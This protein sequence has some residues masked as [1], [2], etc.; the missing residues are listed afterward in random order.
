MSV[1]NSIIPIVFWPNGQ[2]KLKSFTLSI[3][4]SS[5]LSLKR[6]KELLISSTNVLS[7]NVDK[8][9]LFKDNGIPLDEYDIENLQSNQIIFYSENN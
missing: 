1:S 9:I 3:K 4:A 7:K 8:I 2:K 5:Q 6:L